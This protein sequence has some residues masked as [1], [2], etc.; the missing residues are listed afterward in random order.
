MEGIPPPSCGD[1]LGSNGDAIRICVGDQRD[2]IT[3]DGIR[4]KD[5]EVITTDAGQQPLDAIE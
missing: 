1:L 5:F 2:L 3:G 4:R